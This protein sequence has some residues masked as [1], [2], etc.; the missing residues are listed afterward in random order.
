MSIARQGSHR[1]VTQLT[2][3][4]GYDSRRDTFALETRYALPATEG[5]EVVPHVPSAGLH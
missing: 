1:V 5:D 2:G 4:G 3:V